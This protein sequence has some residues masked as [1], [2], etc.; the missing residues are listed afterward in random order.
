M[1]YLGICFVFIFITLTELLGLVNEF[2]AN[3]QGQPANSWVQGDRWYCDSG[4]KKSGN[5]CVSIFIDMGKQPANSSTSN[6]KLNKYK[7]FCE[8]IGFKPGTEKF[9]DCVL[10]TMEKD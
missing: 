9:A 3:A 10:K 2:Q 6:F 5:E 7:E 1:A 4:Y 8:E